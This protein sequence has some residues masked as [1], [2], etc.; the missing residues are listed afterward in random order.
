MTVKMRSE[1]GHNENGP[2]EGGP[3]AEDVAAFSDVNPVLASAKIGGG[4]SVTWHTT[5]RIVG[6][7]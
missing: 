1:Q 2:P 5:R 7:A 4:R 3:D 6:S